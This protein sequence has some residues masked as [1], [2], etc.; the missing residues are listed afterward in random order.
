[1]KMEEKIKS[2]VVLLSGGMDS[3]TLLFYVVKKLGVKNVFTL[4]FRYGQKHR[5]ELDMARWQAQRAGVV[6]HRE[7]DL[8]GLSD[9]T[10][11]ASALT[12]PA[13][14]VPSLNEIPESDRQ[15]PVT[16]VPNRNMIFI[17]LGCALAES[18]GAKHIFYGA[19][20]QDEYGYWDCTKNF[21]E[22]MNTVLSLNR[23][24]PVTLLAPFVNMTKIDI[25]KL[26]LEI[27]VDYEHTWSCYRGED[28]P[29]GECPS[30]VARQTAFTALKNEKGGKNH[31]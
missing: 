11:G 10:E 5:R 3:S 29:C 8:S 12:D 28:K 18:V 27:G 14:S 2:A 1:M 17:S 19:Q 7:M 21:A 15:Q 24:N 16:Y 20:A 26:G 13:I 30:C 9:I 4:S 23:K 25:L 31:G 6:N 22:G